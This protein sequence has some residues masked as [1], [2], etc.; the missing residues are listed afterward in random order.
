MK[1][2]NILQEISKINSVRI[3]PAKCVQ[4]KKIMTAEDL[5]KLKSQLPFLKR[6]ILK[7]GNLFVEDK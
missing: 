2:E 3:I 4:I 1:S 5:R 6:A 7:G